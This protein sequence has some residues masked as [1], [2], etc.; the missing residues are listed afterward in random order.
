MHQIC[1]AHPA[2]ATAF[3]KSCG[4]GLSGKKAVQGHFTD[5]YQDLSASAGHKKHLDKSTDV[6]GVFLRH[7]EHESIVPIPLWFKGHAIQGLRR[8][9]VHCTS[10]T[11]RK[12]A[13]VLIR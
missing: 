5:F 8:L 3:F 7:V 6:V 4:I 1:F 12:P 2:T 10:I 11:H 9:T 13:L